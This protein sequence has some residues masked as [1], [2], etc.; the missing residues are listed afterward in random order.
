MLVTANSSWLCNKTT[1]CRS[2]AHQPCVRHLCE[3]LLRTGQKMPKVMRQ[4]W[5]VTPEGTRREQG[6]K[7]TRRENKGMKVKQGQR[8]WRCSMTEQACLKRDCDP[9]RAHAGAEKTSKKDAAAEEKGDKQGEAE[10]NHYV[11]T[12]VPRATHCFTKGTECNLGR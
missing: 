3:N 5:E 1:I 2:R 10:R 6:D 7:G 9:W 11:L 12:S 8:S 4:T